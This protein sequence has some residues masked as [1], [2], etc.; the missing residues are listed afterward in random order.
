[1]ILIAVIGGGLFAVSYFEKQEQSREA[2]AIS[3]N[4]VSAVQPLQ[5]Y[6]NGRWYRLRDGLET[7]LVLGI[8]KFSDY[9]GTFVEGDLLNDLQSDVLLLM[10]EDKAAGVWTALQ[11]NRDTMCEIRRLGISGEK[12]GTVFQQLCLSHTYGSGGKDSC[13]NSVKAVSR[14]LYDVPIDHYYAVTMDAIPVLNDL[15][16]GVT[17]HVDDDLTAADPVLVQGTDVTLHGEQALHFVRARMSVADGTNLSRMNRQRVFL[18][19][20]YTQMRTRLQND[21]RFALSMANRLAEYSTSDLIP[22]ELSELA[23]RLKD[24]EFRGI[25]TTMGEAIQGEKYLEFYP[26]E[27]KLKTEVLS[28]FFEPV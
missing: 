19:A 12:T 21:S 10:I 22:E 15:V 27:E 6:Y 4:E 14:L 25:Q 1:M 2:E 17:V 23:E 16:G 9:A 3:A 26:D 28:L 11:L 24:E 18:D 5:L 8:D 20:L 13:R 7:C